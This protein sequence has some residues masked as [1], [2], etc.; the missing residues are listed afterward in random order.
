MST[1]KKLKDKVLSVNKTQLPRAYWDSLVGLARRGDTFKG[2]TL[3]LLDNG[4][5]ALDFAQSPSTMGAVFEAWQSDERYLLHAELSSPHPR[6]IDFMLEAMEENAL[7]IHIENKTSADDVYST[8]YAGA[9]DNVLRG[10]VCPRCA[11]HDNAPFLVDTIGLPA[12]EVDMMLSQ[13]AVMRM[14]A[15]GELKTSEFVAEYTDEGSECMVGD[16]EFAPEA[17]VRCLS[18]GTEAPLASFTCLH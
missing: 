8:D 3:S 15:D 13:S 1:I 2:C 14:L 6:F 7:V 17:N 12:D 5:V 10:I 11:S 16:S 18:C 4:T 9:N